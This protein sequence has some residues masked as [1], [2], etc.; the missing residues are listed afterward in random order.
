MGQTPTTI[1]S[2]QHYSEG[3]LKK[4]RK[5]LRTMKEMSEMNDLCAYATGSF[6]RGD[7]SKASDLDIFFIDRGESCSKIQMSLISADLI[8]TCRRLRLPEFSEGGRYLELHKLAD[9]TAK[10]GSP[11]DDS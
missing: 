8:R 2:R 5:R 7:A 11:E 6:A 1:A 4:L 9:I 10:L 3:L